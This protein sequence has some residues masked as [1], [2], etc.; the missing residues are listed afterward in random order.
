MALPLFGNATTR[1]TNNLVEFRAGKMSLKGTTVTP[2]KRK[3]QVY[4]YKS[5]D[6]L[7]HFCWKDR[8]NGEVI[9]DLII[10][11]DDVDFTRVA[12][13]TTGRVYVLKFRSSNRKFF[14]WVQEPKEDKDEDNC[15]KV[16][17]IL[18]GT[19][20]TTPA[21]PAAAP[22]TQAI[23]QDMINNLGSLDQS[24]LMEIFGGAQR[25]G[26]PAAGG[27]PLSS[28]T[29]PA[30]TGGDNSQISVAA[31]QNILD[32]IPAE[33]GSGGV[34]VT[35]AN[36]LNKEAINS[37]LENPDTVKQLQEHL[38]DSLKNDP[39]QLRATLNSP[40]FQQALQL[41]SS[42]FN[43]GQLAPL[44]THFGFTDSAGNA[45]A[46]GDFES[47]VKA[48]QAAAEKQKKAGDDDDMALD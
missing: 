17:E 27:T 24:Q 22:A 36:V 39:E 19:A 12:Q 16:N 48:L 9:D 20:P 11:P 25:G 2:D 43:S 41:F 15:K 45:A 30:T 6:G 18:N 33:G 1:P 26:A 13:C 31:L 47:F 40:Q 5:D 34:R 21:T 38:P 8:S 44:M 37:L 28:R 14:F 29:A 3:G 7:T 23:G 10:F 35:P 42:A 46:G 4:I 32:G